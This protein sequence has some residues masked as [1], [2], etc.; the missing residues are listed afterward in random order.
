MKFSWNDHEQD[1]KAKIEELV[2]HH[3]DFWKTDIGR[4]LRNGDE[5]YGKEWTYV[6]WW[7]E[8]TK[9]IEYYDKGNIA[10]AQELIDFYH[11]SEAR[12]KVIIRC[13]GEDVTKHIK[14]NPLYRDVWDDERLKK[15]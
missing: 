3:N 7:N 14:F 12:T 13:T 6:L 5:N 8:H 15:R 9:K 11:F 4:F 2:K 10:E 1:L